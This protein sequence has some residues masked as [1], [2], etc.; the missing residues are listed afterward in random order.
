MD[1]NVS[2]LRL[3]K[4]AIASRMFRNAARTWGYNDTDLDNFDPLVRLLVEAC[5]VEVYNINNEINN[6]QQRMLE[7]LARLLTPEVNTSAR[8]AHSILHSKC[9]EPVSNV[10]PSVQFFHHKKIASKL[11]G[12]LDSNIDLFF[13]PIGNYKIFDG[14]VKF[15]AC[16]SNVYM[17]NEV[18]TKESFIRSENKLPAYT[19]W[20]A[21]E[22]NARI[23]SLEGLSFFIDFKNL[24]DKESLLDILPYTKWSYNDNSLQMAQGI[25]DA[26]NNKISSDTLYGVDEFKLTPN[27][28]Q[29]I[30]Q[31]YKKHFISI[32][33][34]TI[35]QE[36]IHNGRNKY[37]SE[38]EKV[39]EAH[40]LNGFQNNLAWF[41]ITFPANFDEQILDELSVSINCYPVMNRHLNEVR[42]RL[43]SYFNIIPLITNEQFL[44]IRS[45]QNIS[46]KTY[47]ANPIEKSDLSEK[48]TYALRS[49]GVERFDSRNA[50]E[51][52]NYLTE[53]LRDESNAFAAYGQDFIAS[54]IKELKQN[55]AQIEQ[56]VQQNSVAISQR[57]TFLFLKPYDENENIF[58]EF[59]S[60]NG[61]LANLIRSGVKLELYSGTDIHRESIVLMTNTVGGKDKLKN[62]ELVTAYKNTLLSRGRIVTQ[63]D[64]KNACQQVFSNKMQKAEV[65]KGIAMSAKPDEGLINTVDVTVTTNKQLNEE[66]LQALQ[67]ELLIKLQQG[68]VVF[69]NYR[70]IL[71]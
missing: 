64:I 1:N 24:S 65:K 51:H 61:E 12:P 62:T 26:A 29:G 4:E 5:A 45:V 28:E 23:E 11:N 46:G 57:S 66:E 21:V 60:T 15:I 34:C 7:R 30:Y 44:D 8:P 6:V 22:L 55:I 54:L 36:G 47:V 48:G 3:S 25:W 33:H 70:V 35:T 69:S 13:S 27:I 49:S 43:Q 67:H 71:N 56:K 9:L 2:N 14:D 68:S 52:L 18:Q 16:G 20:V 63:Q 58:V 50:N 32:G 40:E 38:F 53:L 41:K 17:V 10:Y 19:A 42:Y 59:W 31:F 37:P 39:F